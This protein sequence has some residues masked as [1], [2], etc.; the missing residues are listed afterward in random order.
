MK[1]NVCLQPVRRF[2]LARIILLALVAAVTGAFGARVNAQAADTTRATQPQATPAAPVAA[3]TATTATV[4]KPVM[5]AFYGDKLTTHEIEKLRGEPGVV[6][7]TWVTHSEENNFG[8]NIRRGLTKDGEFKVINKK[9][10]QGA[11]NSSTEN[12]YEFY[13]RGIK[14]GEVYYYYIEDISLDGAVTEYSVHLRKTVDHLDLQAGK[15]GAADKPTTSTTAAAVAPK[16]EMKCT[17]CPCMKVVNGT[18][19]TCPMMAAMTASA[20]TGTTGAMT[21]VTAANCP[22][23]A[24]LKCTSGTCPSPAKGATAPVKAK[25]K[26]KDKA[27]T[28]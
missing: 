9:V 13:D 12:V 23:L 4:K 3:T 17:S 18:T 10:I 14:V 7:L 6:R 8:F 25:A 2:A 1:Q 24:N 5:P 21:A 19:V 11:G 16:A 20:T 28:N 15:T 26:A 22:M 27:I